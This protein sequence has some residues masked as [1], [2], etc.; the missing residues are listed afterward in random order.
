MSTP[1][2]TQVLA[3]LKALETREPQALSVIN[4]GKYIQHNLGAPDGLQ[5]LKGLL[6]AVPAGAIQVNTVR[7][8]EDGDHVFA[9]SEYNFGGAKAGFDVFR[10]EGDQIVEHWDNLQDIPPHPNPSGRGLLDGATELTELDKTEANKAAARLFIQEVFLER[11]L[12][13]IPD[14]V[15]GEDYLQHHPM[16]PDG[17]TNLI[18]AIKGA[19]AAGIV[20]GY[21]RIHKVLGEG[22][23]VLIISE[24]FI[25]EQSVAFYDLF[26]MKDGRAT[27]HWDIVEPVPP[28]SEWK[29]HNGKF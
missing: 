17:A 8:F 19:A 28:R 27:E 10:F 6:A 22:N 5:G 16:I 20:V 29:N 23:F 12:E 13:R 4:P 15:A 26:R 24:G 21:N 14:L 25:G 7:V 2:K 9:H 18:G 1:R 3:L 11:K